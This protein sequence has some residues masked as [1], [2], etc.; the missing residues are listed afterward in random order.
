[1]GAVVSHDGDGLVG[2]AEVIHELDCRAACVATSVLAASAKELLA[3]EPLKAEVVGRQIAAALADDRP[4]AARIGIVHEELIPLV[5]G[6]VERHVPQAAVYAPVVRVSGTQVLN[7]RVTAA[8]QAELYPRVR[9]VVIRAS[10][11]GTL[12]GEEVSDLTRMRAAAEALRR[13]GARAA[14]VAGFLSGGRV[15]DVV[16]DGGRLAVFDTTRH[17]SPRIPGLAGAYAASL[18]AHLAR[19]A[20]LA[21]AAEAAQ[22][23]VGSRLVRGR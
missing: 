6:L 18:A 2:D 22:R 1:V 4:D 9:V 5:A 17:Q 10:D 20:E 12:T 3:L 23:Y 11:A 15:I 16:D 13:A 19:G 7:A 8:A 21:R 14:I